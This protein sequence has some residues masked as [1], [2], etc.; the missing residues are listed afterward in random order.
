[1]IKA[2]ISDLDA[3]SIA[4][5]LI[6]GHTEAEENDGTHEAA[7]EELAYFLIRAVDDF[8][9]EWKTKKGSG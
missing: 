6:S 2:A 4:D 8:N 1:V 9:E 7:V 3:S 5:G